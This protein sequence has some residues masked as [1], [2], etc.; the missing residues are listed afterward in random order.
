MI[1]IDWRSVALIVGAIASCVG[2][3]IG[4]VVGR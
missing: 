4:T 1:R 2:A 3:A